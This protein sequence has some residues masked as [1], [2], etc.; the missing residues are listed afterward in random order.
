MWLGQQALGLT[1]FPR[2][3]VMAP[4]I[5]LSVSSTAY[6]S[7]RSTYTSTSTLRPTRNLHK[8][9]GRRKSHGGA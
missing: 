6:R 5:C 9:R 7:R 3:L 1:S 2:K 8:R 4:T